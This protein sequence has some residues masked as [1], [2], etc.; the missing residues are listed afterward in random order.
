MKLLLIVCLLLVTSCAT[1]QKQK[2]YEKYE[3][4][5]EWKIRKL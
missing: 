1:L 5:T 4:N 2:G 3:K